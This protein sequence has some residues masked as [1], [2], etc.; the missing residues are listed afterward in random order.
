MA[1]CTVVLSCRRRFL[2]NLPIIPI[3]PILPMLC[4]RRPKPIAYPEG[5][6]LRI[7][8]FLHLSIAACLL[9]SS[10]VALAPAADEPRAGARAGAPVGAETII[11]P[12]PIQ[13]PAMTR[14]PTV[15]RTPLPEF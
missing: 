9:W 15:V 1:A 6:S 11:A 8:R 5:T 14:L 2:S 10:L 4:R 7:L 13:G 3:G 12:R